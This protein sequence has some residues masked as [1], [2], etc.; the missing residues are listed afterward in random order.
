[1]EAIAAFGDGTGAIVFT[2]TFRRI[3]GHIAVK[4]GFAT[5]V[6]VILTYRAVII[7][8]IFTGRAGGIN[9]GVLVACAVQT[10]FAGITLI[11]ASA[12]VIDVFE[13]VICGKA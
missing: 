3:V 9:T 8:R 1:M 11:A 7:T 2:N 10:E 6:V 4:T 12:T 5:V 13:Q